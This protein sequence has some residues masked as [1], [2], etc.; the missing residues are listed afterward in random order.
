M[1]GFISVSKRRRQSTRRQ[2]HR[3]HRRAALRAVTAAGLYLGGTIPGLYAAAEACGS[4][5]LYVRAAVVLLRSKNNALL[6]DVLKG[7]APILA[8]AKQAQRLAKLVAAYREA[9]PEDLVA[10]ARTI[11][12]EAVFDE[13]VSPAIG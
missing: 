10:A 2:F 12:G 8:A 7:R 9:L 3:G 13:M 1:H 5:C 6:N 4:N 11:G